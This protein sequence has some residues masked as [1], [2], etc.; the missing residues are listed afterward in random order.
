MTIES[1]AKLRAEAYVAAAEQ[2]WS[3]RRFDLAEPQCRSALAADPLNARATSLLAWCLSQRGANAEARRLAEDAIKLAPDAAHGYVSLAGV[4]V[5][6]GRYAQAERAIATALRVEPDNVA[7]F[8]LLSG[9]HLVHF[10][11]EAMLQTTARGLEIDPQNVHLMSLRA[12][13]LGRLRRTTEAAL[14][15]NEVLRLD[16][17][18]PGA[19]VILGL[20]RRREGN[21][22]AAAKVLREAVRLDPS[23]AHYVALYDV[24]AGELANEA[25]GLKAN[26]SKANKTLYGAAFW[27]V[28]LTSLRKAMVV[29]TVETFAFVQPMAWVWFALLVGSWLVVPAIPLLERLSSPTWIRTAASVVLMAIP[30]VAVGAVMVV[31]PM[32]LGAQGL[33]DDVAAIM[34]IGPLAVAASRIGWARVVAVAWVS[35]LV[36]LA[37]FLVAA[38]QDAHLLG[39]GFCWAVLVYAAARAPWLAELIET[40]IDAPRRNAR[41]GTPTTGS[42]D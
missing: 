29:G 39:L 32:T 18:A 36:G 31:L 10:R 42:G 7:C 30:V 5:D 19:H 28:G 6:S 12:V 20:T 25:E 22:Q 26:L 38:G 14:L 23:N 13:A 37:T 9:I 40:R 1:D 21:T 15:A 8:L 35:V 24:V 16:P 41:L 2:F 33:L 4:L 11:H 3:A 34:L 17:K 27:W